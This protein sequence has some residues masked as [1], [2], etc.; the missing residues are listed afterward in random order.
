MFLIFKN[1]EAKVH[2]IF[3]LHTDGFYFF[4]VIII[5]NEVISIMQTRIAAS[6]YF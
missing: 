3:K 1:K 2:E 6:V 4:S 5:G